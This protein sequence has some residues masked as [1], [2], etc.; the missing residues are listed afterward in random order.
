MI[1]AKGFVATFIGRNLKVSLPVPD[2]RQKMDLVPVK[3]SRNALLHYVHHSVALSKK[4]KLPVFT[5]VNI[6]S[7]AFRK[8]TRTSLFSGGSDRWE[9]DK[10]VEEFQ[11]GAKLYSGPKSDFDKGHLVKREDP[12]WGSDDLI[13]AEAA[14]STFFYTNCA[15]QVPELNREEWRSLEDYILKVEA[16]P[17]KL[18][19]CVFTG[20]V[21][22][23]RDPVFVT[24]VD[25]QEVQIP[26]H[27]W[28]VIY[29]TGDGKTLN[30]VAFM[31]GQKKLLFKRQIVREKETELEA[32][33]REPAL[34]A[35]FKDAAT[36]QVNIK[37]VENMTGLTFAP[38]F[39]PFTDPRPAEIV[40]NEVEVSD[41][42]R[43]NGAP[44]LGYQLLGIRL[45]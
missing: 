24:P 14:R 15:P 44:A 40:K 8:I 5:A 42:E 29:Y 1:E 30:R 13:A 12:Q 17:H 22:S 20:P 28:K 45:R 16:P 37:S 39:D 35:G 27:F 41:L 21:L 23:D 32:V 33:G 43:F 26:T 31:M 25:G 6:D 38:A 10:R 2:A 36:Y 19:I 34:F 18:R 9:V 7:T 4:R 11:W 3:G